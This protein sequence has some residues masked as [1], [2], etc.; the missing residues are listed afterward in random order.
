VP[1]EAVGL[2]IV[3]AEPRPW[4][5]P[6]QCELHRD[7]D[8]LVV[9]NG[10]YGTSTPRPR[11]RYRCT[12]SVLD[13][14]GNPVLEADGR[15]KLRRH[16]FTPSLPRDHVHPGEGGC[17]ECSEL[18]GT[19]HGET[20]VARRHT[21]ATRTVA[22]GLLDLSLGS[23]YAEVSLWALRTA[24]AS[25]ARFAELVAL[26]VP[27][28][29]ARAVVEDEAEAASKADSATATLPS[30]TEP[31]PRVRAGGRMWIRGRVNPP[32][33]TEEA[34]ART[35]ELEPGGEAE[36]DGGEEPDASAP[37]RRVKHPQTE[38]ANNAWHV[39][40]DWCEAFAP[41]V[42]EQVEARLRTH[43]LAERAR[44]DALRGAGL[45]L[46]RPQVLLVD[47]VPVY[48]RSNARGGVSRRDEGFFLLAAAET[49]WGPEPTDPMTRAAR[50][51]KLR[52]V[53]AMPKSNAAAWRLLF[54]E[55]DYAPDFIVADAGTGIA[56]AIETHFDPARTTLVP[57]LWHVTKAIRLGLTDTP[58]AL[59]SGPTGKA[60]RPEL[61]DH[62]SRL[63]RGRVLVDVTAWSGWWDELEALC[64][65]LAVPR[66]KVRTRRLRYEAPFAAAIPRLSAHAEVP[67]STGGLETLLAKRV[68]PL[69]A[70][71]RT[72]FANIERTNRLFDLV[73]AREHGAFDDLSAVVSLLREDAEGAVGHHGRAGWTVPLRG[74]ADP[75]PE[76]GRY[77]SLRDAMLVLDLAE[78]RGLT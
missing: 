42:F 35:V 26:G 69:L 5:P 63:T 9:R 44:L 14:A 71:R 4:T 10:T 27:A 76:G 13:D 75:R 7:V 34:S 59:V 45:P 73:I 61:A 72:G 41:V 70:M 64:L 56:R 8:H 11:Q 48:G 24:E 28:E 39:A 65:G 36:A 33:K 77:S 47:D 67:V 66:D 16:A 17:A 51:L 52:A 3:V 78:Q 57:S 1:V 25:A 60:L 22:R 38:A 31:K 37:K 12:S 6:P 2:G 43:A 30:Q 32:A 29:Q 46:E 68:E 54:D 23:S 58:G 62:L 15:P 49:V 40:A 50:S 55:L 21:W 74:V 20:A 53:R 19:H 18:R